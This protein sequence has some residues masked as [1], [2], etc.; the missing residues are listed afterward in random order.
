MVR[1]LESSS[2]SKFEYSLSFL[3]LQNNYSGFFAV[4]GDIESMP[5]IE[6]LRQ[7]FFSV[8]KAAARVIYLGNPIQFCCT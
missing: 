4:S 5:F 8:G 7:L 2:I 3:L 1:T 6:A